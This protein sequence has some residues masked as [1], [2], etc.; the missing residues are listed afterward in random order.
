MPRLSHAEKEMMLWVLHHYRPQGKEVWEE[1]QRR[2]QTG[3]IR[4]I[5]ILNPYES[6]TFALRLMMGDPFDVEYETKGDL[7]KVRAVPVP[8]AK[9]YQREMEDVLFNS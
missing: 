5:T 2:K 9:D 1:I 6:P 4:R 7:L 3:E 8:P